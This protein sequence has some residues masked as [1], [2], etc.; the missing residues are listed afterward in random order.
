MLG[1]KKKGQSAR[2]WLRSP[3]R[4]NFKYDEL[5]PDENP[6]NVTDCEGGWCECPCHFE[7]ESEDDD[8]TVE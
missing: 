1:I 7:E 5:Y 3:Q 4:R 2:F 6:M 8:D